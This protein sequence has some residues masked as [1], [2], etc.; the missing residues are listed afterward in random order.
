MA[1]KSNFCFDS[2]Q[3]K[4]HKQRTATQRSTGTS[5]QRNVTNLQRATRIKNGRPQHQIKSTLLCTNPSFAGRECR[6]SVAPCRDGARHGDNPFYDELGQGTKERVAVVATL[7]TLKRKRT[8]AQMSR[9]KHPVDKAPAPT[10]FRGCSVRACARARGVCCGSEV[11]TKR[12]ARNASVRN[13][14][15][16]RWQVAVVR[17][18]E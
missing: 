15:R 16:R 5:S 3:F 17:R 6:R 8:A 18:Q 1:A 10:R 9:R 14:D 4:T 12:D 11:G 13:Y 2:A 7:E